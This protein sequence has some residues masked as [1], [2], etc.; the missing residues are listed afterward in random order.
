MVR[1]RKPLDVFVSYGSTCEGFRGCCAYSN[2]QFK[3]MAASLSYCSS[4]AF[5]CRPSAV[6]SGVVQRPPRR[7]SPLRRLRTHVALSAMTS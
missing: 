5:H 4:S 1:K 2:P 7:P 3:A 6:C